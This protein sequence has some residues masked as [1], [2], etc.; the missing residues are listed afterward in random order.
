MRYLLLAGGCALAGLLLTI[1][2][3]SRPPPHPAPPRPTPSRPSSVAHRV[4]AART[5]EPTAWR[6]TPWLPMTSMAMASPIWRS[7]TTGPTPSRSCWAM[8]TGRCARHAVSGRRLPTLPGGGSFHGDNR[9]DLAAL[10]TSAY[11]TPADLALLRGN[12]DG[13]FSAPTPIS[14]GGFPWC[15]AAADFNQDGKLDLVTGNYA[16]NDVSV[17][18]GNGDGGFGPPLRAPAGNAPWGIAVGDFNQDGN[19]IWRWPSTMTAVS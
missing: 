3:A 14:V 10:I 12:G 13:T 5:M 16:S 1:L 2:G 4:S 8:V 9:N 19:R 17:L 6:Q 7:P 18:L 11:P 15:V